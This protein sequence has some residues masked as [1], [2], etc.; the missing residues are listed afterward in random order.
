M[1][2]RATDLDNKNKHLVQK[3]EEQETKLGKQIADFQDRAQKAR[4]LLNE[5]SRLASCPCSSK[6]VFLVVHAKC[7]GALC[8][9]HIKRA[10]SVLML[11]CADQLCSGCIGVIVTSWSAF[12][13]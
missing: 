10:A 1:N 6:A 12:R 8:I 11:P 4:T 9:H 5:S 13:P 7:F 2:S 3:M